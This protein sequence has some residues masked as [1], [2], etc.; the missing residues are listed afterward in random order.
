MQQ[1]NNR[2]KNTF[3]PRK[4]PA[5]K[6][7]TRKLYQQVKKVKP[8]GEDAVERFTPELD[9]GL[10]KDQIDTRF[11]QGLYNLTGK[12]YSKSLV[13]IFI[14]NIFTF[15]NLLCVFAM[16][17]LIYSGASITNYLFVVIFMAN[18]V[19]GIVQ[20]I[21]AKL[22]IDKLSVLASANVKVMR[23]GTFM[24]IPVSEVV[25]DDVLHLETGNQVPA[26]CLVADGVV[27]VNESLLTGESVSIKKI[28]GDPIYAGSFISSGSCRA[29]VE[30]VGKS[31]YVNS[32]TSQAKKYKKPNS[33]IMKSISTFVRVIGVMIVPIAIMMFWTN[34]RK[35]GAVYDF[36]L[37][38]LETW[39][40]E[41]IITAEGVMNARACLNEA[42]QKTCAII[43]GM[44]P[45]GMMLLTSVAL[46]VGVVRLAKKNTLVQD[47][48]SLEMLARVDVLCLDKT[49]TIT[50]GRMKVHGYQ[51][52]QDESL[53]DGYIPYSVDEVI[54]SML[55]ALPDN[56]QTSI[57]LFNYFG[58]S[59]TLH[60]EKILPF[61]SKRKYSAVTFEDPGTFALG[62]PEFVFSSVPSYLERL[63]SEYALKGLRVLVLAYSPDPIEEDAIPEDMTPFALIA[64]EDNIRED[65]ISSIRWFKENGVAVKVISGD[66]AMTVAEVARRAGVENADKY[67]S[68]EGLT[69][70]EVETVAHEYTVFGRVTPEQKRL[71]VR[72]LKTSGKTVAMTGDGVNDLLALKEADCAISVA[73]GAEAARNVS[74]LV[75]MDNNFNSMPSIVYE[76]R[77]VINNIEN[78]ASLYLMK[79]LLITCLALF[80]LISQQSY[81][82]T[83]QNMML[84]EMF[85][86]GLPSFILSL[87]PNSKKV[88]GKFFSYVISHSI[89]QAFTMFLCVLGVYLSYSIPSFNAAIYPPETGAV[90]WQAM[91][92]LV[93]TLSGIVMLYQIC[94]PLNVLRGALIVT[95]FLIC[96]LFMTVGYNDFALGDIV[97]A[98]YHTIKFNAA[99]L[100]LMS[101]IILSA[102]PVS[103][104][105][106]LLCE[107][108]SKSISK[109]SIDSKKQMHVK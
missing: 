100:L 50:D 84:F 105:A 27:E 46:A 97:I 57:A 79:T 38:D 23:Y 24:E 53:P 22:Q 11:E 8:H 56:N 12:K 21:R 70:T 73:S 90:E 41:A 10:T 54:S 106:T 3:G 47:L 68:L 71:L 99:E 18:I 66:N 78:S 28:A 13:N 65:A 1:E 76:G 37:R 40:G 94:K 96:V 51:I 109:E 62:A 42:I 88:E 19:I 14:E 101:T 48:Y 30:K 92:V 74:H 91:M 80:C 44:I 31:T 35:I 29:R 95:V 17:A 81:F 15:F 36:S 86:S 72:A 104:Y 32:L 102:F 9:V 75:L 82:F 7:R 83:T 103:K 85:V 43:V 16:I 55:A 63:V 39:T 20:E 59:T 45:S 49:G 58:H 98:N 34:W 87:Q 60:A 64:I 67:I 52:V 93:M 2:G 6:K 33:E 107:N 61:S 26:D 5:D 25:L 77:R 108:M 4:Q 69:D 89:P